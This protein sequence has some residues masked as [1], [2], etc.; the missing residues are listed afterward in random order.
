M[1]RF[2]HAGLEVSISYFKLLGVQGMLMMTIALSARDGWNTLTPSFVQCPC[3]KTDIAT[4]ARAR[5]SVRKKAAP[6][7]TIET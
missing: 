5:S 3:L 6:H 1:H 2:L 7:K 4:R